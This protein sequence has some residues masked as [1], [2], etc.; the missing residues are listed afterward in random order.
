MFNLLSSIA[1]CRFSFRAVFTGQL[2]IYYL[3]IKILFV[4][5]SFSRLKNQPLITRFVELV[6][7]ANS[8]IDV[9][10]QG[11]DVIANFEEY[12]ELRKDLMWYTRFVKLGEM[13]LI[14]KKKTSEN[15]FINLEQIS[16][17][18]K[19]HYKWLL[20]FLRRLLVI[21]E[22]SSRD[23]IPVEVGRLIDLVD[24]LNSQLGPMYDPMRKISK[25]IKKHLTLPSAHSSEICMNV[26]SKLRK[27]TLK[28]DA[29]DKGGSTLRQEWRIVALQL[30]NALT[31]KRRV[32]SLWREVYS[33]R[34]ID[35]TIWQAI[36]ETE[37]LCE[38]QTRLE[39]SEDY[40]SVLNRVHS[41]LPATKVAQLNINTQ[42]W[43]IYE[44][45]FLS[46]ASTL[47]GE[48]CR[49]GTILT[50]ECLSRFADLPSVPSDLMGLL[51]TMARTEVEQKRKIALLPE[52]FHRIA[53]F[54]Q[55]S[56]AV[57]DASRLLQWHGITT[58][59]DE[60]LSGF[61]YTESKVCNRFIIF[62]KYY[63]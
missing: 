2:F 62:I 13:T 22:R 25:R 24:N 40:E 3:L 14:S 43:P 20:K 18:L 26:H 28:L 48:M 35:T 42:L 29:R 15:M 53:Q 19:V 4:G 10:L 60:E 44:Y 47:Q 23:A 61:T 27:I 8:C 63:L 11:Y 49:N 46:L 51:D 32:I 58:T 30:D 5:T 21:V 6:E 55:Q 31:T 39:S 57:R 50:A 33:G 37:Q 59:E 38:D 1:L 56:Y 41:L 45:V 54:A 9:I 7:R 36:L 16:S 12:V 52:L 34:P 17:L